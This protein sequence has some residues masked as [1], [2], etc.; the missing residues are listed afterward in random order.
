MSAEFV[1]QKAKRSEPF[2]WRQ[3][4]ISDEDFFSFNAYTLTQL[5]RRRLWLLNEVNCIDQAYEEYNL[6]LE[7]DL[8]AVQRETSKQRNKHEHCLVS[9]RGAANSL[10]RSK[11][12]EV[13]DMIIQDINKQY[14]ALQKD[15]EAL[16]SKHE[17]LRKLDVWKDKMAENCTKLVMIPK[18]FRK[19]KVAKIFSEEEVV[20]TMC[21]AC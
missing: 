10:S 5:R 6:M 21:I 18:E 17:I 14:E 8:D 3:E 2:F 7:E 15:F 1:K 20:Q 19:E 4:K 11:G 13:V 9:L 12:V 16:Q